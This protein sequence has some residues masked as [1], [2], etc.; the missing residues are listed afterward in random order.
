MIG[1][2]SI[3]AEGTVAQP[4]DT[5]DLSESAL[6]HALLDR[7]VGIGNAQAAPA[8]PSIVI[9]ELLALL[10]EGT[11]PLIRLG[12]SAITEVLEARSCVHLEAHHI[13]EQVALMYEGGDPHR[14]VIIGV[15]HDRVVR[16]ER[17]APDTPNVQA[18]AGRLVVCATERLVL[19]CGQASITLTAA[20]KVLI[21]GSHV[22]SRATGLNRIWGGAVEIN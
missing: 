19:R 1:L 14:P 13:G 11:R 7:G 15:M 3:K 22:S 21:Q 20:G 6:L 9:G 16:G 8:L 2:D 5:T 10:D 12:D 18:E 4:K 17:A